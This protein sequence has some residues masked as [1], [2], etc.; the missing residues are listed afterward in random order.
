M[1]SF[2]NGSYPEC[3]INRLE[4]FFLPFNNPQAVRLRNNIIQPLIWWAVIL[5]ENNF[6]SHFKNINL[7]WWSHQMHLRY[8]FTSL[9]NSSTHEANTSIS[10]VVP[11][12]RARTT[13]RWMKHSSFAT[14]F[15]RQLK[16]EVQKCGDELRVLLE[17]SPDFFPKITLR[18]CTAYCCLIPLP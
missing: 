7:M 12:S 4:A 16:P 10:L 8:Y 11:A 2:I 3:L 13:S 9:P 15:S 5:S 14:T 18:E 17:L 1:W 6:S